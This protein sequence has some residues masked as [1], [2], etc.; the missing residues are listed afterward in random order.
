MWTISCIMTFVPLRF[1]SHV[2]S[3]FQ[4]FLLCY[5]DSQLGPWTDPAPSFLSRHQYHGVCKLKPNSV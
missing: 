3:L 4:C 2:H 5:T 1:V